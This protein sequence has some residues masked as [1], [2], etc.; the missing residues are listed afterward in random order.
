[1]NMQ[2][3]RQLSSA[4]PAGH[5]DISIPNNPFQVDFIFR[6]DRINRRSQLS[7]VG[8]PK[9]KSITDYESPPSVDLGKPYPLSDR[10]IVLGGRGRR[11]VYT[12]ITEHKAFGLH[13]PFQT[14]SVHAALAD[15]CTQSVT[16]F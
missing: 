11:A 12:K 2:R 8:R 14:V 3:L 9:S 1:M 5:Q 4:P 15:N 6:P 10:V 7:N 13:I 16:S